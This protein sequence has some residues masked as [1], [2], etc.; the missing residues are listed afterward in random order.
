MSLDGIQVRNA[1]DIKIYQKAL[2]LSP[3]HG[4]VNR[5]MTLLS[6]QTET[7]KDSASHIH[8]F[9]YHCAQNPYFFLI[10]IQYLVWGFRS[11]RHIV[12][13]LDTFW[14]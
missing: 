9:V 14:T 11:F 6:T 10:F 2:N 13:Y 1:L 8:L 7:I 5:I 3:V 4:D 12:N